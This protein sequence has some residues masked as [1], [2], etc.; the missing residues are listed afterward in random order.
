MNHR[1]AQ[2]GARCGRS[3]QLQVEIERLF[4]IV[5]NV[6]HH[7]LLCCSREARNWYRTL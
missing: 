6:L 5:A 1:I 2:I 3:E 4:E 7:L